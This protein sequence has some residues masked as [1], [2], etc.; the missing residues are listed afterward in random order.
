MSCMLVCEEKEK[1]IHTA[2]LRGQSASNQDVVEMGLSG[3][4]TEEV[5][6]GL[7]RATLLVDSQVVDSPVSILECRRVV[8]DIF[9]TRGSRAAIVVEGLASPSAAEGGVEDDGVIVEVVVEVAAT[10][11]GHGLS[12]LADVGLAG[13]DR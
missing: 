7:G 2:M 9:D 6:L 3:V 4:A 1:K 5:A 8:G 13:L 11:V 12:E 10:E